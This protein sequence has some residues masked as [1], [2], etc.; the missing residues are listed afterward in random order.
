MNVQQNLQS[1]GDLSNDWSCWS[2]LDISQELA[3]ICWGLPEALERY[4]ELA[5]AYWRFLEVLEQAL[6][7]IWGRIWAA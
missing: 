5:G 6:C 2:S 3:G 1:N 4:L 7:P